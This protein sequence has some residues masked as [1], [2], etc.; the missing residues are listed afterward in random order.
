M[1]QAEL[2]LNKSPGEDQTGI[3]DQ[4]QTTAATSGDCESCD[5]HSP[6]QQASPKK[7]PKPNKAELGPH[8]TSPLG[9][10]PVDIPAAPKAKQAAGQPPQNLPKIPND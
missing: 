10:R 7:C 4:V 2:K 1:H 8:K 6:P 5:Q 3:K 9:V